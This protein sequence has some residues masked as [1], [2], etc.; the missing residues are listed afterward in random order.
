M[1]FEGWGLGGGGV[2]SVF[3]G[4]A[5]F[6]NPGFG[7]VILISRVYGSLGL[8]YEMELYIF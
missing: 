2:D 7:W 5:W 3:P 4:C 1:F 8:V 6:V